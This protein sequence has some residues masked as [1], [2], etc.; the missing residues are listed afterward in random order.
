MYVCMYVLLTSLSV[1]LQ[2]EQICTVLYVLYVLYICTVCTVCTVLY[3]LCMKKQR[4]YMSIHTRA[5][6]AL[7]ASLFSCVCGYFHLGRIGPKH[8]PLLSSSS[9]I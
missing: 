2:G 7:L 3:V 1:V 9:I 6:L 5:I 8:Q 4:I